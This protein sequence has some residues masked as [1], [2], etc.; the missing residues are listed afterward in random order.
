MSRRAAPFGT[1]YATR[2]IINS[3][4]TEN[5]FWFKLVNSTATGLANLTAALG[6]PP[7]SSMRDWAISVFLDDNSTNVD[8]RFLQPSWNL[9]SLFTNNGTSIAPFPLFTRTLADTK[10]TSLTLAA[11]GVSFIRFSV[12]S[13]S[14]ALLTLTSNGGPVTSG[15]QVAVVRVK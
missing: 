12:A 6:S 15:V 2:R 9:R 5:A 14:D 8:P 11:G 4:G 1:T 13:G 10:Q 7:S 3:S